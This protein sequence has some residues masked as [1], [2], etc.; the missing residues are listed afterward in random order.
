MTHRL[1]AGPSGDQ[2]ARAPWRKSSYSNSANGC[3]EAADV[4]GLVGVRDSKDPHGPVQ[5]YA[6]RQWASFI[7]AVR[8]GQLDH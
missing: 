7:A 6:P 5:L 4:T 3:V 1:E 8:S 2:L